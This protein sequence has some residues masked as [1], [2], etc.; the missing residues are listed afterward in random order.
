LDQIHK[1]GI[2]LNITEAY[3]DIRFTGGSDDGN[4]G[5]QN[6]GKLFLILTIS[7]LFKTLY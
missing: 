2:I 1:S 3:S 7:M 4:G 6:G 5:E